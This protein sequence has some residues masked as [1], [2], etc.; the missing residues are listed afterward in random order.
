VARDEL[1]G[2]RSDLEKLAETDP[3]IGVSN[4][5]HFEGELEKKSP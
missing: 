4:R 2:S 5:R 3:L 1:R